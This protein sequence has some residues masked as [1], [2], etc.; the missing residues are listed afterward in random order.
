LPYELAAPQ[1]QRSKQGK[2]KHKHSK[3]KTN[4]TLYCH[5][6]KFFRMPMPASRSFAIDLLRGAAIFLVLTHHLALPFR[7]PL[8]GGWCE[9]VFGRRLV[10]VLSYSGYAAV[11]L[12]FTLSGFL[13]ARRSIEQFGSLQSINWRV[14]YR[15]RAR[16][17][18]PLL[19]TLLL[20]LS[21]LHALSVPFFVIDRE[22][23]SWLGAISSALFLHLNW[24]EGQT[25]WLPAAWDVLWSLSIE[26]LFYLCFPWLCL[27]TP[28]ALLL[29][30][31]GVLA[32]SL[33]Y[34]KGALD[35][36]EI[37]QEKAYLPAF[38]A[39]AWGIM[40]AHLQAWLLASSK[41]FAQLLTSMAAIG[42]LASFVCSVELWRSYGHQQMTILC[43]SAAVLCAGLARLQLPAVF[44]LHWLANMGRLSY[45]LYLTHM[46]V[47]IPWVA[48]MHHLFGVQIY[49]AVLCYPPALFACYHFAK[50]SE[51]W[52]SKPLAKRCFTA[53]AA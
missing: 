41:R 20:V 17:I 33:P 46:L 12:F 35:G 18:L 43:V 51:R 53:P 45:E 28:R 23:Q 24:Y 48:L 34:T 9:E 42:L 44:G 39:I 6:I 3:A 36:Q 22:G 15:Q 38:S 26:E 31:L 40:A 1:G 30:A 13:I 27:L 37:W 11:F 8:N 25:T 2:G 52:V 47:I 14:F 10:S 7:L 21:I 32:L 4:P 5:S 29:P 16:R 19:L 49:W 50:A